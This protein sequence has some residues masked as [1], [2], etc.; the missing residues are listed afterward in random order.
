[1]SNRPP[2]D[3]AVSVKTGQFIVSRLTPSQAG[4]LGIVGIYGDRAC[5]ILNAYF[6]IFKLHRSRLVGHTLPRIVCCLTL[7]SL[8]TRRSLTNSIGLG[9]DTTALFNGFI[10]IFIEFEM[11]YNHHLTIF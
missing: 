3:T 9:L 4:A 11:L 5:P 2:E 1:M 8:E 10:Q 6:Q 7:E